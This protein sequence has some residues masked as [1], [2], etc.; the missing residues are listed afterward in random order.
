MRKQ[1][2]SSK[3]KYYES[4]LEFVTHPE[5]VDYESHSDRLRKGNATKAEYKIL[6]QQRWH[7]SHK[8]CH[9]KDR[10]AA[11]KAETADASRD[12]KAAKAAKRA[13]A[14]ENWRLRENVRNYTKVAESIRRTHRR[15]TGGFRKRRQA[16]KKANE[17]N[18]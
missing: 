11:A 13:V 10:I 18:Q 8:G 3:M 7:L 12:A 16:Q 14:I 4:F 2:I 6:Q 9:N 1:I 5:F 17:G 15:N